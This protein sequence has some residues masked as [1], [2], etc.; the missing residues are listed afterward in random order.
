[1]LR[2]VLRLK[3]IVTRLQRRW[4]FK[5]TWNHTS[6]G[7]FTYF[8]S[9]CLAHKVFCSLL[10]SSTTTSLSVSQI[11]TG[12]R[13]RKWKKGDWRWSGGGGA[14]KRKSVC[15]FTTLLIQAFG[16]AFSALKHCVRLLYM[17]ALLTVFST[18]YLSCIQLGK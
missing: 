1:M 7:Y 18:H 5:N 15:V 8:I 3:E 13:T 16:S 14:Q 17:H 11:E 12:E 10:F 9:L 2:Y 4:K 6:K